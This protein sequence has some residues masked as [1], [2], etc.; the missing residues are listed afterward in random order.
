VRPP[1][2]PAGDDDGIAVIPSRRAAE[3][4]N[5]AMDCMEKESRIMA[6]IRSGKT[7][8]AQVQE[9]LKWEKK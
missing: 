5:H 9:L 2:R 1:R 6:E 3:I 7:T 4:A 8:L